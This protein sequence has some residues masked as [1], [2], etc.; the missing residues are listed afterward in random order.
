MYYKI[1]VIESKIDEGKDVKISHDLLVTS[2]SYTDA[3]AKA[4]KFIEENGMANSEVNSIS[5]YSL[6][7]AKDFQESEDSKYFKSQVELHFDNNGKI[8]VVK[9]NYIVG[10][11][12]ISQAIDCSLKLAQEFSGA[13][14]FFVKSVQETPFKE[15]IG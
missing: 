10:T 13:K 8:Q 9:K 4:F 7:L 14:A 11:E 12:S 5:K 6:S 15:L 3:E 1:K 2:E